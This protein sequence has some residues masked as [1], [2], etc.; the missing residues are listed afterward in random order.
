[1]ACKM[2]KKKKKKRGKLFDKQ[3]KKGLLR[4][5]NEV[6]G[7]EASK[8]HLEEPRLFEYA[9]LPQTDSKQIRWYVQLIPIP[10][11]TCSTGSVIPQLH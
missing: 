3:H 11:A 5:S 8:N 2:G 4:H 6:V 1:M 7:K 9:N 10:G